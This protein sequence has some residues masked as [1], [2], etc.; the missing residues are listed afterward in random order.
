MVLG[1]SLLLSP[2]PRDDLLHHCR[3]GIG[4][5][6]DILPLPGRQLPLGAL[7]QRPVGIILTQVVAEEEHAVDLG[8]PGGEDVQIEAA[9]VLSIFL[10]LSGCGLEECYQLIHRVVRPGSQMP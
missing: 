7:V 5:L 10:S 8:T 1:Q 9:A 4:V 6:L 3:L 2:R